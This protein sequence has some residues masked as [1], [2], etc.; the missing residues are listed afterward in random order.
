M[1]DKSAGVPALPW[2]AKLLSAASGARLLASFSSL[3]PPRPRPM[4]RSTMSSVFLHTSLVRKAV[5]VRL[6]A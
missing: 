2:L 6:V 1:A 3:P 4:I 5:A